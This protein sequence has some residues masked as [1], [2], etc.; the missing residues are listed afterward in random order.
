M[1]GFTHSVVTVGTDVGKVT[2]R[3]TSRTALTPAVTTYNVCLSLKSIT[4]KGRG[5]FKRVDEITIGVHKVFI[6]VTE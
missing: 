5:V 2:L 6:L 1:Q 4:D 3:K